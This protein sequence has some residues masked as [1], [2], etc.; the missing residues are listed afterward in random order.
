MKPG[1]VTKID[2]SNKKKNNVKNDDDVMPENCDAKVT[3]WTF[4]KNTFYHCPFTKYIHSTFQ[5]T[6]RK[7]YKI[8]KLALDPQEII[9]IIQ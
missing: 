5:E 2:K 8:N 4:A 3:S 6:R 7:K 9:K 1:P